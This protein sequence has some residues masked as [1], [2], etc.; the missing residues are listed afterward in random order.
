MQV[1]ERRQLRDQ[2]IKQRTESKLLLR[3]AQREAEEVVR[4]E[5]KR[6]REKTAREEKLLNQQIRLVRSQLREKQEA[7]HHL[8]VER[9][10]AMEKETKKMKLR[11]LKLEA[12]EEGS[13]LLKAEEI[14]E[15]EKKRRRTRSELIRQLE[16]AKAHEAKEGIKLMHRCFSVWYET[17][18]EQRAKLGK[19][20][21]VREWKVMVRVWGGWRR[22]VMLSRA[23][24]ERDRATRE[25][26]RIKRYVDQMACIR[27]EHQLQLKNKLVYTV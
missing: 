8:A 9:K 24:R 19:A 13:V 20:V 4:R 15:S 26:Q 1:K 18:V 2:H 22:Y 6:A 12:V 14:I 11:S 16:Q 7:S 3:E 23:S 21:A 5:E 10:A 25:M 27:E 17:V